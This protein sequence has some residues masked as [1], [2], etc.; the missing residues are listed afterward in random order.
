[1]PDSRIVSMMDQQVRKHSSAV[2]RVAVEWS[3]FESY[4]SETVRML[5][6][7]DN[8]FGECITVQIPDVWRMLDAL[9][10]PSDLRSPG[11]ASEGDFKR[12]LERIQNLADRRNQVIHNVWT[13]DPGITTRWP[14]VIQKGRRQGPVR[15]QTSEVDGLA[16]EIEKLSEEFLTF[17]R[18]FLMSLKL[19]PGQ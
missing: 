7:V 19:W 13:F 1:M 10:A 5:A 15:M 9:S 11:V 2:G 4:L 6:E 17:R 14:V 18:E 16:L 8:E 3:R 12:R